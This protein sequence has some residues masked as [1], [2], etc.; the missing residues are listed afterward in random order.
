MPYLHWKHPPKKDFVFPKPRRKKG[1][2]VIIAK[3]KMPKKATV[4]G[5]PSLISQRSK[6]TRPITLATVSILKGK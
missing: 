1:M 5:N 4:S 2:T 6:Q 3:Q